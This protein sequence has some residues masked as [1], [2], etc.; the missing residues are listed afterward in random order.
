MSQ[1]TQTAPSGY[2]P[3]GAYGI[4]GNCRSAALVSER[5]SVDW[6]CWPRFDSPSTFGALLDRERGGRFQLCPVG[7]FK[8]RRRYLPDTNVLETT[9]E[10]AGGALRLTDLMPVATEDERRRHLWPDHQLLRVLDCVSGEVEVQLTFEPRPGYGALR[11]KLRTHG[12]LG[13]FYEDGGAALTLE[14]DLPFEVAADG[15]SA[16][17]RARLRAGERRYAALSYSQH[18]PAILSPP[19]GEA[20]ASIRRTCAW[21]RQWVGK[22]SYHGPWA[23][24]VRRSALALKLLTFAPS[25]AVI[26]APTTSLPEWIGSVRNWDYRFCWLRDASLTVRAMLTLGFG[27][28]A[29]AFLSWLLHT[30]RL[31]WPELQ[32]MYDVYGN[33]KLKERELPW[34][35]GYA[36]SR[37]VRVG[38]AAHSQLQLDVYGEVID[39]A[40][41]FVVN[42]GHLDRR[43]SKALVGFGETVCKRWQ[44]PDQGIWEERAEPRQHTFSK[45]MCWVALDRLVQL[46]DKDHVR[47]PVEQWRR[48]RDRIRAAVEAQGYDAALG[49][50]ISAFGWHEVDSS[51]L[52]LA[53]FEYARADSP[54]MRGTIHLVREKLSAGGPLLRRYRVDR[55][56]GLPPGQGAFGIC[57]FWLVEAQARAGELDAAS[58]DFERLLTYGNDLGLFSE[59]V[60]PDTGQALG[61]FP[62]GFTHIGLINAAV[63]IAAM[64]GEHETPPVPARAAPERSRV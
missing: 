38:N 29:S 15:C 55:P 61:N 4:V 3:I 60:D 39:A 31:T 21:W 41:R 6:L 14:T 48:E 44:E 49:S 8:T 10:S 37:P 43:T 22:C 7:P 56:D 36:G 62:Q 11:P 64:R 33:T 45:V 17:A 27:E 54:R 51:L 24:S 35:E 42:G 57:S 16:H 1:A 53:N 9:F 59:Q 18:I 20:E 63:T 50:Y 2:P 23:G 46:H 5:G 34:L 13:L 52:Q 19:G 12:A 47:G 26:A 40:L 32:I 58:A 30:T 25:G 28:E